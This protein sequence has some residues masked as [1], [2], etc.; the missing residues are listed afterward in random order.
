MS[1]I[2]PIVVFMAL[3]VAG[4][5]TAGAQTPI[6]NVHEIGAALRACW[7]SPAGIT[8][9]QVTLR[10]SFK[11][12]GEVIGEPFITYPSP[13]ASSDDRA[14]LR[15]VVAEDLKRCTPLPL[16]DGFGNII[17]GARTY[18]RLGEGWKRREEPTTPAER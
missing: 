7:I 18:V 15:A 8:A 1:S 12:N 6:N 11:R 5:R 9:P 14:A 3:A 4:V 2:A 16:S 10:L 17:A 13:Y